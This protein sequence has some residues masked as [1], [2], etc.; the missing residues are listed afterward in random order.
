MKTNIEEVRAQINE[1]RAR[2]ANAE[3][4]FA[5][6]EAKPEKWEPNGGEYYLDCWGRIAES[7]TSTASR[8][9]GSEYPTREAAESALPYVTFYKRLCCL[10]QELNPSGKVGGKF[11]TF[12]DRH[13]HSI[14]VYNCI[15]AVFETEEAADRAAEIMN[16]DNWK[17]PDNRDEPPLGA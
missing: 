14:E 17:L 13:W 3:A 12:S 7:K 6:M 5:K 10:A 11:A 16:R 9:A 1:A 8:I 4:E 2:L 15:D